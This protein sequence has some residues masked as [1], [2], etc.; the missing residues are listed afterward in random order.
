MKALIEATVLA[1]ADS[2]ENWSWTLT[3]EVVA[4]SGILH[5]WRGS[6]DNKKLQSICSVGRN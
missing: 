1:Q 2:E 3:L 5:Q 6:P 4:E